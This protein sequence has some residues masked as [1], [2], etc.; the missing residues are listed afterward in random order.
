MGLA[1]FK[2]RVFTIMIFILII[3]I[4]VDAK[5]TLGGP[6][7]GCCLR[8]LRWLPFFHCVLLI[9]FC[10]FSHVSGLT[11]VTSVPLSIGHS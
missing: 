6:C 9:V 3:V 7:A 4:S 1:N 5:R 2:I 10:E 8:L 11:G